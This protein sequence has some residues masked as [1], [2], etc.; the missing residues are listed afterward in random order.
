MPIF[1]IGT[2]EKKI[3]MKNKKKTTLKDNYS[4]TSGL[5]KNKARHFEYS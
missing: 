5:K 3:I 4:A 2:A 1:H